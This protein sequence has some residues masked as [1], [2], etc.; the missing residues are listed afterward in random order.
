[1]ILRKA[2]VFLTS[3]EA[4]RDGKLHDYC[5]L[6]AVE[7]YSSMTHVFPARTQATAGIQSFLHEVLVGVIPLV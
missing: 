6:W 2:S 4:L 1:M 7:P 5:V 3:C